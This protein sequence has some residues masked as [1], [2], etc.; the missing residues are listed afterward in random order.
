MV[1][2]PDAIVMTD[3][4]VG[5]RTAVARPIRVVR[6]A[7]S[8]RC[9][10]GSSHSGA[11]SK[12]HTRAYPSSSA[13]TARSAKS[14]PG[15]SPHDNSN[16]FASVMEPFLPGNQAWRHRNRNRPPDINIHAD[17][18]FDILTE[19]FERQGR[20]RELASGPS[21]QVPPVGLSPGFRGLA[22]H[23]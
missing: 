7:A 8:A 12:I 3:R 22:I 6:V 17:P 2:M 13:S 21:G 18:C 23:Q 15:G 11:E 1:A 5:I 9:A 19:S 4:W 14:G 20:H 10:N 16:S